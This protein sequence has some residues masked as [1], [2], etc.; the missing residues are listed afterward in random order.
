MDTFYTS[1][2]AAKIYDVSLQTINHWAGQFKEHLSPTANPGG[3][4]KRRFSVEDMKVLALISD[5]K[6]EGSTFEDIRATLQTGQRGDAPTVDP[7][8]VQAIVVG[9]AETRLALENDRLQQMLVEAHNKLAMAQDQL[10]E[11][12]DLRLKAARLEA[13][14]DSQAKERERLESQV[15]ALTEAIKQLSLQ[16]GQEYAKGF[17]TGWKHRGESD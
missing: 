3:R 16:T 14:L 6:N 8:Q 5:M 1:N 15:Q 17:E 12:D 13:Q 11:M 7:D 4:R 9:E 2:Q 10:K